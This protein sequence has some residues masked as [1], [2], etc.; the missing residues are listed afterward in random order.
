MIDTVDERSLRA[1]GGS[2][3]DLGGLDVLRRHADHSSAFL[4]LNEGTLHYR[5]PDI[6]GLIAF[7]SAG[8]RHV[9][10]LCGPFAAPGDRARLLRA[11]LEWAHSQGRRV[12]AVQL[13]RAD[14]AQYVD[15][16]FVANQ[17]GSSYSIDLEQFT[18]RGV[19]FSSVR[20]MINRARRLGL[21]VDELNPGEL[22]ALSVRSVL[23]GIDTSWLREKGRHAK[24]LA[25]MVGERGG[26]GAR[27]RRV[28]VARVRGQMVAYVSYS[29]C[30]GSRP[31][32]LYDLT[33]RRAEAPRGAVDIVF[34]TALAKLRDEGCRWLHLGLTPFAG[35]D[36]EHELADGSS[37]LVR[38][39]LRALSEH[40]APLYPAHSQERF[41]R[42]WG[43]QHLE[44]EYIAF[45]PRPSA[46]AAWQLMRVTRAI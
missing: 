25:F 30:F 20:N 16:G 8:R 18:L 31:G 10:Q 32:W 3:A 37:P 5:V 11:F 24:E 29:P 40:G 4:A 41:K 12:T 22:E 26:R 17:F 33:R 15:A 27:Y 42:K 2:T 14:A 28:F 39:L 6:D 36:S 46:A 13:T 19:K 23:D 35:L 38:L 44:P 45:E 21:T 9:I 43:P 7:R 1:G 34:A